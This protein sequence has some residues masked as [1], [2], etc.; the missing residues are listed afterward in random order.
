MAFQKKTNELYSRV[1]ADIYDMEL[2]GLRYF[3]VFG[4]RQDP[5]GPYAAVIPLFIN[6]LLENKPVGIDGD[7][8]QT[9]DFTF[10][11]NVVQAN[12]KAFFAE[13]LEENG[14]IFNVGVGANYSIA[15][16]YESAKDII[17]S[18]AKAVHRESRLGDIRDSLADI[19]KARKL[20]GYDPKVT[21]KEGLKTTVDFFRSTI[22]L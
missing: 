7:G 9:R 8:S 20:L 16:L 17:G 13:N 10:I 11:E 1:F 5:N 2:A 15:D 14:H 4:P 22:L 12:V 6:L 18:E 19:S 3:N 21:F